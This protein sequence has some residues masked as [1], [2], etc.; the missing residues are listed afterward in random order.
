MASIALACVP[1]R[2]KSSLAIWKY[3]KLPQRRKV[4]LVSLSTSPLPASSHR[5]KCPRRQALKSVMSDHSSDDD[6]SH[7]SRQHQ[8]APISWAS[9]YDADSSSQASVTSPAVSAISLMGSGHDEAA[10]TAETTTADGSTDYDS[11]MDFNDSQTESSRSRSVMT[12]L[13][14]EIASESSAH[15]VFSLHSSRT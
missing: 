4:T 14:S 7:G 11:L 2:V 12:P 10:G 9:S 1:S 8:S 3:C 6:P 15:S 5:D 13:T